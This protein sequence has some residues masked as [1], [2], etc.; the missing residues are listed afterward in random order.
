MIT[1]DLHLHSYCSDGTDSPEELAR[2]ARRAGLSCISLVDHDTVEGVPACLEEGRLLGLEVIPGIE[3]TA[4]HEGCEVHILGYMLDWERPE[5]R[6]K[7]QELRKNRVERIYTMLEKLEEAGITLAPEA[8]FSLAKQGTVGRLH[9]ARAMVNA[10]IVSHVSEAFQ[11]YIGDKCPAYVG[12]FM[13]TPGDA[14]RLIAGSGGISVL[15]HP[16]SLNNDDLI[17]YL[18][19]QGLRGLE[20]Y[21]PEHSQ[22]MI[23]FYLRVAAEF[24]LLVT[25]GSDYHGAAKPELVLGEFKLPYELVQKLKDA[26]TP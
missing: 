6:E 5:L 12:H 22:S 16:Y 19:K 9:L 1:A 10:G 7:L 4:E 13:L 18:A 26:K 25:G 3:L 23:N 17:G 14:I 21:Y 20:V 2:K 11:R 24:N 8:V 15:A